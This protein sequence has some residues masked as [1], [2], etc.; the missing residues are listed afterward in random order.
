MQTSS[1]RGW[2]SFLDDGED[3]IVPESVKGRPGRKRK[4]GGE[5]FDTEL[6]RLHGLGCKDV[7]M[8]KKLKCSPTS[9][10]LARK[11]LG[12][13]GLRVSA[14][15]ADTE[16]AVIGDVPEMLAALAILRRQV[17][18]E[19]ERVQRAL[20]PVRTAESVVLKVRELANRCLRDL[21]ME[22]GEWGS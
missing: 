10:A 9:I 3:E 13:K 17:T 19:L 4:C 12:L 1:K 20:S 16:L 7:A 6:I 5:A 21:Q 18:A 15:Y 22:E 11:R 14:Y 2:G 8:A